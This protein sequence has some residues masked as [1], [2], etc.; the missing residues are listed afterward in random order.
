MNERRLTQVDV[1]AWLLAVRRDL[2]QLDEQ[3]KPLVEEQQR[4][5]SREALLTDLLSSFG[6]RTATT[7]SA[8]TDPI[9][10]SSRN[11]S[12]GSYVVERTME[13]LR[14]E[15]RPLHINDIH[16]KFLERGFAVPGAGKAANLIVHLRKSERIASPRRGI[17]GLVEQVG[18]ASKT[19]TRKKRTASRRRHTRKG[20][21][22]GS[23]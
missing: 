23:S 7:P 19:V 10:S 8:E 12:T 21:N 18:S 22:S 14:D 1:D 15:G 16:T 6:P 5:Q 11:G 17:Y 2:D 4:L 9:R 20:A 13:I 3:L